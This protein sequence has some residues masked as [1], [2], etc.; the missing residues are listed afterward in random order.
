M[1][2]TPDK[3]NE[4]PCCEACGTGLHPTPSEAREGRATTRR[5]FCSRKCAASVRSVP[6]LPCATCGTPTPDA[7]R[8]Y[9]SNECYQ[10]H[11]RREPQPCE[12]CGVPFVPSN[13]S[14]TGRYC[15]TKCMGV[16]NRG[17]GNPN[18]GKRH[19]G[20]WSMPGEVRARL[21][22]DRTAEGNPNWSGGSKGNGAYHFQTAVSA[23]TLEAY[24]TCPCGSP[25]TEAQH[26]V[27]RRWFADVRMAHFAE[28]LIGLCVSCHRSADMQLSWDRRLGRELRLRYAER[29]PASILEQLRTDGSV[30]RLPRG[31]DWSPL[32]NVA[33]EVLRPEW[34]ETSP[35]PA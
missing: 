8:K 24:S 18:H 20:M 2:L 29:L 9:C 31:L 30:S 27:P 35:A 5:R 13:Y 15:S 33:E 32:G 7:G 28:N 6:R 12:T 19:P 4:V 14:R 3:P 10:I 1:Q 11:H 16:A 26:V 34:F 17:S 25:A 23:W 21:S 22:R